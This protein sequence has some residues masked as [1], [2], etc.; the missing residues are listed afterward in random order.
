MLGFTWG[1]AM[2][3]LAG[4]DKD[5]VAD[6]VP[7]LALDLSLGLVVAGW[8]VVMELVLCL[9]LGGGLE[10]DDLDLFLAG[11]L[12]DILGGVIIL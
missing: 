4:L 6:M 5:L 7:E 10:A 9:C 1:L 8:L 2:A 12:A 11:L 3:L